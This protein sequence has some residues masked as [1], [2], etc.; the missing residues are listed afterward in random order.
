MTFFQEMKKSYKDVQIDA[1]D[2]ISTAEFLEA[3]E[4]LTKLFGFLL[5]SWV[6][7]T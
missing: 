4:S 2:G 1:Q 6:A 3:T 7:L 5:F